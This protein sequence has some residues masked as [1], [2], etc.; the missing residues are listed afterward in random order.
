MQATCVGVS[1]CDDGVS[2]DEQATCVGVSSCVGGQCVYEQGSYDAWL[3]CDDVWS[4]VVQVICDDVWL[5]F[6]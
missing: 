6:F 3:S 5:S 4:Y 1:S 2:Y